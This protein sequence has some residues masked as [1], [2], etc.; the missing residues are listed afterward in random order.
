MLALVLGAA[1]T[2]TAE[3]AAPFRYDRELG[4]VA[5]ASLV[6]AVSDGRPITR[7]DVKRVYV[8]CYRDKKTFERVFLERY[9]IPAGRVVAYYA[10]GADLHLRDG[11]CDNVRVFLSGR[12]TVYTAGAYAILLHEALHRQGVGIERLTSCLANEAVRWGAERFGFD[13][14]KGASRAQ[15]RVR[16]HAA[17]RAAP[18]SH[19]HAE[20][21][22][23][24]A[25]YG[26]ARSRGA[27]WLI[28]SRRRRASRRRKEEEELKERLEREHGELLEELRSLIPGAEVLFG[29]LL[30]IRFTSQFGDLSDTQRY[31]YY[32]TLLSTAAALVFFLAP[33]AYHRVRFRAGDKEYM[34]RKGNREAIA[35]SAAI[36]IA[37]TG[38]IYLV[39]DLV[40][41]TAPGDHRGRRLLRLDRVVVVGDRA[42][43]RL[44]GSARRRLAAVRARGIVRTL[45]LRS[46][47]GYGSFGGFQLPGGSP[48]NLLGAVQSLF[49]LRELFSER[50]FAFEQLRFPRLGSARLGLPLPL[51]RG[52]HPLVRREADRLELFG[53]C[54]AHER[55]TRLVVRDRSSQQIA[56]ASAHGF[57]RRLAARSDVRDGDLGEEVERR[58]QLGG[59]S[60]EGVRIAGDLCLSHLASRL[61]SAG[62]GLGPVACR[63]IHRGDDGGRLPERGHDVG[64]VAA[65]FARELPDD[66]IPLRDELA[67]LD[68]EQ[69]LCFLGERAHGVNG[70]APESN[71]PSRGLHDR[72]GFEDQLG[73]RAHA[74]PRAGYRS[75][76]DRRGLVGEGSRRRGI[77]SVRRGTRTSFAL[78]FRRRGHS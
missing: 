64:L 34:V 56:N 78:R 69:L 68:G 5:R 58:L 76:A 74:A 2:G 53:E 27:R 16:V 1:L 55:L 47:G 9:G 72:T 67:R 23:A 18:V 61:R 45:E 44:A 37:F 22:R 19:G 4:D 48:R 38:V 50:T 28:P 20:L 33:A 12:H 25:P 39:T 73:H 77:E 24:D 63:A 66:P 60:P 7:A 36:S 6:R 54:S 75:V 70:A 42:L 71:R 65:V 15:S 3:A 46:D 52:S 57:A 59:C 49:R 8:R 62:S 32:V 10:G 51:L 17:L 14:A 13:E 41:G 43:S 40:F 30:A 11:T 21:P 29:F 31:V 35:G 26:V